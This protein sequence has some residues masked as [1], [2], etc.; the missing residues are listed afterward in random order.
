MNDM[1]SRNPFRMRAT[2]HVGGDWSFVSMFGIGAIDVMDADS[3]W[4]NM[5]IIRSA[6]GGGKTSILRIFSPKSLKEIHAN[7]LKPEAAGMYNR[8]CDLG[9][10]SE[11]GPAVL[12]VYLSLFGNYSILEQLE[13][14][15]NKQKRLF[16]SLLAC[17]I[18]MATLRS[19]CELK[20]IEF[21]GSLSR[22]T[23][24]HPGDPNVP[25][26]VDFPCTGKELY[27]WAQN[28]ERKISDIIDEGSSNFAGLGMH[29]NLALLHVIK[30]ENIICDGEPVAQKTLL[31]LDDVDRLAPLQR[32]MLSDALAGLRAPIGLWMAERLE[33]LRGEE[34]LSPSGTVGRECDKPIVIEEYWK[35]NPGKFKKLLKDVSDRRAQQYRAHD[36][37]SFSANLHDS[38]D[39]RWDEKFE[40]AAREESKRIIR[41]FGDVP[42]YKEWIESRRRSPGS[43]YLHAEN[44]RMLEMAIERERREAQQRL[45]ED[46]PLDPR[47]L[48]RMDDMRGVARHYILTRY[49][50]PSCFG[51]DDLRRL[52]SSNVEQFLNLSSKLFD[53][54]IAA[55]YARLDTKIK[56]ARQ[57][58]VLM[59]VARERWKYVEELLPH[60][61]HAVP[62]LKNV[63]QFCLSE[64]NTPTA[65]Y[66]NVTGIAILPADLRIIRSE[67]LRSSNEQYQKLYDVLTTCIAH[68]LLEVRYITQGA[69]GVQHFVL[70][71]NRLLCLKFALPLSYGGWKDRSLEV[72]CKFLCENERSDQNAVPMSIGMEEIST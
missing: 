13:I 55:T 66:K 48:D 2:E 51:F 37:S 57:N 46:E 9:A 33:G 12:G 52:S 59:D 39:S 68:N 70:Y 60:S 21:P 1:L 64:T 7:R 62:F 56:P 8:L 24:Q 65:S 34:L 43:P 23:V 6:R 5:Q 40:D 25:N 58:E 54:M 14:E 4:T 19:V 36:I 63:A 45:F 53:E 71:M 22:I 41:E 61:Q 32:T 35:N 50:I 26:F 69:K 29:E 27:G 47:D 31:M 42:K 16:S 20:D 28:L 44:W 49:G 38:L 72:L 30:A 15:A 17:R 3:M 11:D 18:V 10:L 67:D